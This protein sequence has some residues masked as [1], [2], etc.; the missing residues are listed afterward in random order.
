M[1]TPAHV[2]LQLLGDPALVVEPGP[3]IALDRKVAGL[4]ALLA[5]DG[6]TTRSTAAAL[7]WPD[8]AA[9]AARNSLRQCLHRLHRRAGR[10]IVESAHDV[11]RLAADVTHDIGCAPDDLAANPGAAVGD[12]LGDLRFPECEAFDA[13]LQSARERW[14]IARR[15]TLSGI[16]AALEKDGLIA[17]ALQYAQRIVADDPLL[18]HGHRRL[19][20]LHYL[21]G[22]REAALAAF[23]RCRNN[24]RRA[25]G[26]SPAS[27]TIELAQLIETSGVL[28]VHAD[29]QRPVL[30]LRTPRLVG[31]DRER[32]RLAAAGRDRR[33]VLVRGEHGMG[34]SRLL[35]E[36]AACHVDLAL[37]SA[38]PGDESVPYVLMARLLRAVFERFTPTLDASLIE[39]LAHVLPELGTPSAAS[40]SAPRLQQVAGIALHAAPGLAGCIVDDLHFADEPSLDALL[41]FAAGGT[42]R[43]LHWV[44]STRPD[45]T[46]A[47][48]AWQSRCGGELAIERLELAPLDVP[49]VQELLDSLALPEFDASA[50]AEPL[51]RHTGG[52][53]L[54]VLETVRHLL[55]QGRPDIG[56]THLPLP[57][58]AT[59]EHLVE[60]RLAA[61]SSEALRL[62]RVA[63]LAGADFTPTLA[64]RVLQLHP[65][66]LASAW[67]ELEAA[68]IIRS[69]AFVHDVVYEVTLRSV[70]DEIARLMR[71]EIAAL[72]AAPLR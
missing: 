21:R 55:S 29:A 18:E 40:P 59:V 2:R 65:L 16:A 34:K 10:A 30:L 68:Q 58:P 39:D 43:A 61:L 71:R 42:G 37:I 41:A 53:P 36:H 33:I 11:V 66:D 32:Q 67:R 19:M 69:N 26:V 46:S 5:A 52:N 17:L 14:H 35:G 12:L 31:R 24:L 51:A 22:D 72:Q 23:E 64:A 56:I 8:S 47:L 60:R 20:R 54:F 7:L 70:P 38:R 25:L 27:E 63:A 15:D 6:A 28:P 50:W 44:V 13:W 4:L 62:A 9:P 3:A 48:A 57:A 45:D 49:A 1:T